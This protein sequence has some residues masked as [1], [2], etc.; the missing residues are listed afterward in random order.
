MLDPEQNQGFLDHYMDVPID[1]SKVL[2]V[3]TANVT[4]TIPGPLLDR[5]EVIRLSGYIADE[6]VA[7]SSNRKQGARDWQPARAGEE[8]GKFTEEGGLWKRRAC[9]RGGGQVHRGRRPLEATRGK[10]FRALAIP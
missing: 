4:D 7:G 3:C 9:G 5:M 10:H 1:L 2:F 6:K 8:V